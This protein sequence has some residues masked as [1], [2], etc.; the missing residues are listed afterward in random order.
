VGSVKVPYYVVKKGKYGYWQPTK[1]MRDHGFLP[2]RCG[3]DGP[4]AWAVAASWNERWQRFRQGRLQDALPRWPKGSIGEAFERYR[5]TDEWLIAKKPRTREEWERAW[6]RIEPVFGKSSPLDYDISLESLSIFRRNVSAKVSP[7]EAWR[8]IK[9]WR[10]LWNVCAALGYCG[11]KKD[12]S[13]GIANSAP[14]PRS[15]SWREGEVVRLVKEAWRSGYRGLAVSIALAWDTQFSPVD[16]RGLTVAGIKGKA[17]SR[18]LPVERAKSGRA[19]IGTLGKRS[20]ALLDAYLAQEPCEVGALLRNRS[21]APYSRFTLPDDFAAIREKVFPSDKRTLAD[22]RRSGA[23]ELS[24]GGAAAATT[25]AKMA[26]SI[27]SAN[28]IHKTYQP[29]DI[30]TVRQADAARKIGRSRIRDAN[31]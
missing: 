9:I 10:A 25:A 13:L 18:F 11:G 20:L 19:A 1:A 6:S 17:G 16:L 7:R 8:V 30:H 4:D 21:K 22:M 27:S 5:K 3:I 28:A 26:N 31:D 2:V 14:A 12:P 29:V 15:S 24:A 23:L